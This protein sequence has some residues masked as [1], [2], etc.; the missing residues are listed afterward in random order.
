MTTY[1]TDN[2]PVSITKFGGGLNTASGPLNLQDN[3]SSDL[4]DVDFDKFGSVKQRNGYTILNSSPIAQTQTALG[5]YWYQTATA[6]KA[7]A[8]SGG[9]VYKMDSLDGTWDDITGVAL[10]TGGAYEVD[11]VTF[12]GKVLFTDDIGTPQQWANAGTCSNMTVVSGLTQA[13]FIK[14]F[15]NFCLMANTVVSGVDNPTRFY[16]SSIKDETEWNAADFLEVG[17]NDGYEITGMKVLGKR[18]IIYKTNAIYIVSFTGDANIPFV[19]DKSNSSVGCISHW[20]IQEVDNGHVFLGYDG[21]YYFDGSNSYKVSDRINDTIRGL[22]RQ[23]LQT[24]KSAYQ[25][26]KNRYWLSVK[27]G[28]S[29]YNNLVITW[30]S[31]NNSFSRYSMSASALAIFTVN[32]REE[33]LYFRDALGYTY[34]GDIGSD[35]YPANT[36]TAINSYFWTNWKSFQDIADRKGVPHIYLY[37]SK[38]NADLTFAYAWDFDTTDQYSA[39]INMNSGDSVG[40]SASANHLS[41]RRDLTGRGRVVRFKFAMNKTTSS[42]QIDGLGIQTHLQTKT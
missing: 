16:W 6:Q 7:I 37:Y 27:D 32:A 11:F 23:E 20:S 19:I 31:F 9:K 14:I 18:L 8:V 30:D 29:S 5:L 34:R 40:A 36:K 41:Q 25:K 22:N 39:T 2:V 12:N 38:T 35:D 21:L 28:T 3:E 4:F 24:A 1:Q 10:T 13:R 15:Q 33:R 26:D 42:Y 17:F